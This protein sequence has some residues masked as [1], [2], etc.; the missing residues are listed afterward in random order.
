MTVIERLLFNGIFVHFERYL[1]TPYCFSNTFE[2][3]RTRYLEWQKSK[4]IYSIDFS[5]FDQRIPNDLINLVLNHLSTHVRMNHQEYK[6]FTYLLKYH[7]S[8]DIVS[9]INGTTCIFKKKRGLMSGSALTNLLG[10][11]INLFMILYLNEF[12]KLNV[13]LKSI[14]I[15]GDDII[16]S[17]NKLISINSLNNLYE[18]HFSMEIS[19]DK[20]VIFYPGNRVYFL[21]HFFDDK[22]RYLDVE[23][24]KLQLCI[25]ENYI[26][27][28]VLSTNDR[29]WGKF[30]SILF[31]CSDGHE[32]Y[33]IYY[34]S[35]L[36]LLL[37]EKPI[38]YFYSLFNSDGNNKKKL[39]FEYYKA[40]GWRLQ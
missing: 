19:K 22:G 38:G 8:C 26:S 12:Y 2:Q 6:L 15:M 9:S 25:S 16:F 20:S 14:S 40:I 39:D 32:F 33:E 1:L 11:L 24:T 29:I 3:L 21:G 34:H 36:E 18:K 10:S 30:C 5:S 23:K 35:L 27:E 37:L 28:E 7:L 4:Y 31:K 13:N 17:S